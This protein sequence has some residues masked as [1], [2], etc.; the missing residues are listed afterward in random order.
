[1]SRL[2]ETIISPTDPHLDWLNH[3]PILRYWL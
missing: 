3:F 2:K 1:M